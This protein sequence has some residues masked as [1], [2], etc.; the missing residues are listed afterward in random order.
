MFIVE[1]A[2]EHGKVD[3]ATIVVRVFDPAAAI[4]LRDNF[5]TLDGDSSNGLTLAEAQVQIPG[6]TQLEFDA[7]DAT[8]RAAALGELENIVFRPRGDAALARRLRDEGVPLSTVDADGHL[9]V[10]TPSGEIEPV[11]DADAY[12]K[13]RAIESK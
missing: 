13:R 11:G 10:R 3:S 6:L 2:N 8:E 9:V 4:P 5:G 12:A 1:V 7:L